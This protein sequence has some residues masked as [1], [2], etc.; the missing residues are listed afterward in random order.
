MVF[1]DEATA[2]HA[3]LERLEIF[4]SWA[5]TSSPELDS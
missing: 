1:R 4:R 2:L 5:S 3:R